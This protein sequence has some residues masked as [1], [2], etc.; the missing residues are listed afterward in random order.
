MESKKYKLTFMDKLNRNPEA[1][2]VIIY[3]IPS[4]WNDFSY[5]IRCGYSFHDDIK[6][7]NID[8]EMFIGF[9]SPNLDTEDDGDE[10]F[11]LERALPTLKISEEN[12][13][14][15][16]ILFF[17]M[18]QSMDAY[19]KLV[20]KLSPE[21]AQNFLNTVNDVVYHKEHNSQWHERAISSNAFTLGFMRNSEPFFAYNN[22]GAILNGMDEED[23]NGI[24][25][26]LNLELQLDNFENK[27]IIN[28][29]YETTS[30]LPKR[31]NIFIGKNG[32]GKSQALNAFC[33]AALQYTDKNISLTDKINSKRP[34]INRLLAIMTPG[35]TRNTFPSERRKTQKLY[36][37]K[38]SL[39]R[40]SRT[41]NPQ[42]INDLLVQLA[43]SE[44]DIGESTRWNL[45]ISS[46][47]KV[48]PIDDTMILLK[49][50]THI[51]IKKII[52][53]NGEQKTLTLWSNLD[54][55]ADPHINCDGNLF[56]LSSGQLTFLKFSLLFCLYIENGSFVLLDEPETHMHP[57]MIS[58]FVSLLDTLLERTGSLALIA[59]H[60]VFFVREIPQEQVHV[61]KSIG[62]V[63]SIENP[64][65]TT[66]GS[67]IDSISR[68]VFDDDAESS[69]T[70]KLYN[71]ICAREL[72]FD[73]VVEQYSNDIS[74]AALMHIRRLMEVKDEIS[75][76]SG[77]Q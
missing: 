26:K 17:T 20:T 40:T 50:G 65:L 21:I 44:D 55:N 47:Q 10:T 72:K 52:S 25:Q 14:Q 45:F 33:R 42:S 4:S 70:E 64:R 67:P 19:R 63:I 15:K 37:R 73:A 66:F 77:I 11:S 18:L 38:L 61:F 59:T 32:L 46:I 3:P 49:D 2:E 13:G 41:D 62:R 27:H 28:L 76:N 23:F 69:L 16:T 1:G 43:R 57:N 75:S 53:W 60:S 74:I 30:C 9:I 7:Q 24:S 8:G 22:A 71:K 54:K 56:P 31:I 6:Q 5:K 36:Y 39:T 68:F 29:N 12:P 48:L 34:M 58:D 35:E 51:S